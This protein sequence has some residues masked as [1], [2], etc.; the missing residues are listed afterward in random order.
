MRV[1]QKNRHNREIGIRSIEVFF[2]ICKSY[3]NLGKEFQGLSYDSMIA[4]TT[5]VMTRYIM[6]AVENRNNKDERTMGE[7]FFLIHDELQDVNFS[8]VLR[9]ILDILKEALQDLLFLTDE[10]IDRFIDNFI[11]K[12]P[13]HFAEKFSVKKVA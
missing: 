9:V 7:L 8:E 13:K 6:I 4:H 5:I 2:K 1:L 12:L 3:L 10:Q 11:L